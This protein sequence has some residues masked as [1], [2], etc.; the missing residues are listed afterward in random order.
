MNNSDGTGWYAS[1]AAIRTECYAILASLLGQTPSDETIGILQNLDWDAAIPGR[2]DR[3]LSA[4]RDAADG[5]TRAAIEAEF[6]RLFVGM[7]CG[8]VMPYASWYRERMIQS[9]PLASLRADLMRLG[10]VRYPDNHESEDHA[11]ALCEAMVLLSR[12]AGGTSHAAQAEFF[13]KHIASWVMRFFKDLRSANGADF[14]RSVASFGICFLE[15]ENEYLN[16]HVGTEIAIPKGGLN[17]E[18]RNHRQSASIH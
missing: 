15:V 13:K 2:L 4:L 8:E 10:I 18:K 7:G 17:N 9:S 5:I 1:Y 3:A 11:A 16:V 6:N 14:Y 12:E